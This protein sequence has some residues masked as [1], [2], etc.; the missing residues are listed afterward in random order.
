MVPD[1]KLF[2]YEEDYH[3]VGIVPEHVM[4]EGHYDALASCRAVS[5]ACE[6][7]SKYQ[8]CRST[9]STCSLPIRR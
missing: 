5:R 1:G 6:R 3:D 2:F 9:L 4:E 7:A 8:W